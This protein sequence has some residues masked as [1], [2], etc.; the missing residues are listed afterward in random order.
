MA[1]YFK[2]ETDP[3]LFFCPC[4]GHS[5]VDIVLLNKL[6]KLREL[7]GKPIYVNSGFRCKEHNFNVGGSPNSEHMDGKG[8]DIKCESSRDRFRL[9]DFAFEV[10]FRRIGIGRSF[11]HV[12]SCKKRAQDVIWM[13][14]KN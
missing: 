7:F 3:R 1:K 6:D 2:P 8:A 13:Y 5:I 12:G 11:I 4:C 14:Y 9:I 10:G